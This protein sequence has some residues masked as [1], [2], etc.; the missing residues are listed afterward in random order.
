MAPARAAQASVTP[1]GIG[2]RHPH[3]REL[4][5]R[6]PALDF[7]EVHSENFFAPG[8][9]AL[10]VLRQGRASYPVSLHGVGLSLGSAIGLD[11]WHLDQLARLVQQIEP[12]RVSDHACFARGLLS[13]ASGG[14]LGDPSSRVPGGISGKNPGHRVVHASD[15]L[16][17]PFSAEALDVLCANVQRVQDRLKRPFMVENLS[18]YLSFKPSLLMPV[19]KQESEAGATGAPM[20]AARVGLQGNATGNRAAGPASAL[21]TEPGFLAELARRTGCSLLVDVN[22]IYVNALNAQI[23]GLAGDPVQH[24]LNWLDAIPFGSVGELHLAGHCRINGEHGDEH[25]GRG[26]I[27]IDDHGSRVCDAVWRLYQ[28]AVQRFGAVPTLI[29]W[30][31]DVPALDVLLEEV[32]RARAA[33]AA[34]APATTPMPAPATT[35]P[36]VEVAADAARDDPGNVPAK[37]AMNAALGR[38]ANTAAATA[39]NASAGAAAPGKSKGPAR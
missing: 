5:A 27:V 13:V 34:P 15:L 21:F 25:D 31:T 18:A 30:D 29:E 17:I 3:Y 19:A 37:D 33:A 24:C 2:W 38:A 23:A 32:D 22:N 6:Q 12:V 8:G 39:A 4:L 7:L 9:A 14:H 1:V 16:P 10:A 35:T 26:D 11:D 20:D 36:A 28:H